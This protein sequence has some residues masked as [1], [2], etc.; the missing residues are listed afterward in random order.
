MMD[1]KTLYLMSGVSG[2]G[3]SIMACMILNSLNLEGGDVSYR[4]TDLLW[5][6]DAG[7]YNF[8]ISKLGAMHKKNIELVESDMSGT[9][10]VIIVDNTC[11]T[12]KEANPYIKLAEKYG[13][14]VRV[15][16]V[17]CNI[18]VAKKYNAERPKDRQVPEATIDK[19][20]KRITRIKL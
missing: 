10:T 17:S 19:M 18:D 5:F 1:E 20:D 6:D 16:S 14:T 15:I 4:S 7:N 9:G 12:Q 11:T 3:K 13:Y 2:S 8:D